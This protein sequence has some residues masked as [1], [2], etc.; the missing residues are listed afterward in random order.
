M[1]AHYEQ[2]KNLQLLTDK[3]IYVHFPMEEYES[4]IGLLPVTRFRTMGELL[5]HILG[6]QPVIARYYGDGDG[7]DP[8]LDEI[9][10]LQA[11]LEMYGGSVRR[12]ASGLYTITDPEVR[13]CCLQA[14]V[15]IFEDAAKEL[16]FL[17]PL[18]RDVAGR[19]IDV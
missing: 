19:W 5:R 12:L 7:R 3:K 18:V 2:K 1:A 6:G 4:L 10:A 8:V 9:A 17:Y 14:A 16:S 15:S 11:D 13:R